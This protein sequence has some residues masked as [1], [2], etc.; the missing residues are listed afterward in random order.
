M[1]KIF[2]VRHGQA[3]LFSDNY[4]QLSDKGY[5]Q[6]T[7]LGHYF[8]EENIT[9]DRA[10]LGPLQRHHQTLES[11]LSACNTTPREVK[12]LEGLKEHQGYKIL[13]SLLPQLI[14][15][16]DQI[17]SIVSETPTSRKEKI[18]QHMHVYENFSI[19]WA[20]GEF[21][22]LMNGYQSWSDFIQITT[23]AMKH[24]RKDMEKGQN[25]LVVTSGGPKA[26]AFGMALGLSSQRIM[27]ATMVIYNCSISEFLHHKERF[28]LSTFNNVTHLKNKELRTL[29]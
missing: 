10:Y 13:K 9:F 28:T 19:R 11:I 15:E 6:A 29:V 5:Q 8:K 23:T 17:K 20:K 4:D 25:I 24:I 18:R 14:E 22:H 2:L 12:E 26:V 7:V 27:D 21:D 3:S 16:D 1:G